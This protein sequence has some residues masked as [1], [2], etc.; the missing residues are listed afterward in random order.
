[1]NWSIK[2]AGIQEDQK[3]SRVKLHLLV[4]PVISTPQPVYIPVPG[5]I[6]PQAVIDKRCQQYKVTLAVDI[7]AASAEIDAVNFAKGNLS[8][9]GKFLPEL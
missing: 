8:C 4:K 3:T 6:T 2:P 7:A 5:Q 1:M 9:H